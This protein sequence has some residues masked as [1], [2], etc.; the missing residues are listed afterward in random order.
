MNFNF[1]KEIIDE[2]T[3]EGYGVLKKCGVYKVFNLTKL[4]GQFFYHDEIA[5]FGYDDQNFSI[6]TEKPYLK[7]WKYKIID[8]KKSLEIGKYEIPGWTNNDSDI[9][10]VF[11]G[12]NAFNL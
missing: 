8:Q 5:Y 12:D 9:G 4:V 3:L 11:F 7:K 2:Y 1:S 6:E 10:K